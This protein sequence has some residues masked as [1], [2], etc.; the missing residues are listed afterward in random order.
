[1]INQLIN[2]ETINQLIINLQEI[3]NQHILNHKIILNLQEV[4]NLLFHN[5]QEV[6]EVEVEVIQCLVKEDK[7]TKC[8]K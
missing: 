3:L 1:M 7:N 2:Q 4:I 5:H 8:S 6:Q